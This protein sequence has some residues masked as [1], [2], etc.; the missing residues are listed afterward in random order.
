MIIR[1]L[2]Q[3]HIAPGE[4]SG[5]DTTVVYLLCCHNRRQLT[6]SAI[7]DVH[8]QPAPRVLAAVVLVDDGS[9]DGT[10]DAV[11][12]QYPNVEVVMGDGNLYWSRAMALAQE[13][14]TSRSEPDYLLWLNDDVRLESNATQ[15]LLLTAQ[16]QHRPCIVVGALAD[17]SHGALSYSGYRRGPSGRP[18]DLAPVRPNGTAQRVSTFNGNLVLV[19][20]AV[21]RDL[22]GVDAVFRHSVGDIDYGLRA[23]AA[24]H[25]MVLAGDFLGTCERNSADD[26]WRDASLPRLF[27]LRLLLGP[28]GLEPRT[29]W[30]FQR[31]HGGALWLIYFL[32][33]YVR[34]LGTILRG[35]LAADPVAAAA[36]TAQL[37]LPADGKPD[38]RR[39]P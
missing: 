39:A 24:G 20:H 21:F 16:K 38:P 34:A 2:N 12:A 32:A 11:R 28:K 30:M 10:A 25:D 36:S 18:Q 23:A 14:A 15:Q 9:T 1:P 6:L 22:G 7:R 13:V 35:G 17:P 8:L 3:L 33:T 29:Q 5:A 4:S 19:P 37:A 26:T 27:R 31:R